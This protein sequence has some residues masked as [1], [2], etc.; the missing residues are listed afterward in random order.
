MTPLII[1]T[2]M[3]IIVLFFGIR[4]EPTLPVNLHPLF[5]FRKHGS[6]CETVRKGPDPKKISGRP[7]KLEWVTDSRFLEFSK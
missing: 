2:A 6:V 4:N 3:T 1:K 7:D 5:L